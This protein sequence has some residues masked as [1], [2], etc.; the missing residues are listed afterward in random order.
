[1]LLL[2]LLLLLMPNSEMKDVTS[3]GKD[4]TQNLE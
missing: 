1:M 3:L 2:L 4:Q